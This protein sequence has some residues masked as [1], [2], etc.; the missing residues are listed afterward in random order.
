M[1]PLTHLSFKFIETIVLLVIES[2]KSGALKVILDKTG[3]FE[4][5]I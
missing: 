3:F 4:K 1:H 5:L 2:G